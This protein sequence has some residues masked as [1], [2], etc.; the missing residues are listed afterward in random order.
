MDLDRFTTITARYP[1]LSIAVIGDVCLDRYLDI[2]PLLGETS[3]ETGL[4]VHNVTGIRS[5]P[6]AAGTIINNLAALGIGRI[7]VISLCGDD[8]EGYE[9]RRALAAIPGI[10]LERFVTSNRVRTFAYTKPMVHTPGS[11]PRELERL[12]LKNWHPTPPELA[13]ACAGAVD[14]L[15]PSI[16]AL[17]IMEQVDHPG[18]GIITDPVL[19]AIAR[20]AQARPQ[21]PIIADSRIGLGRFPPVIRKMNAQELARELGLPRAPDPVETRRQA[22]LLANRTGRSAVITLAGD[23]MVGAAPAGGTFH[24]PAM[25]LHGPIDVVGA[26]DSVTANLASALAAGATLSEAATIA[27]AAASVVIHQLGTTGTASRMQIREALAC[28]P[29]PT[30]LGGDDAALH[31]MATPHP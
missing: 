26:G 8:G 18:T 27:N 17:V 5:L 2:D 28:Q 10:A 19:A 13:E 20:L 15:S 7:E 31:R 9:L 30:G 29:P 25:P 16:A 11:P 6:G 21:L 1:T 23:G 3:L 24:I 4:A 14:A 12:D 22:S